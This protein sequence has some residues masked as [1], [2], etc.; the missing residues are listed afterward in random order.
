MEQLFERYQQQNERLDALIR[1]IVAFD[2]AEKQVRERL[3][4]LVGKDVGMAAGCGGLES[5]V[6]FADTMN[7]DFGLMWED[8][9]EGDAWFEWE[10]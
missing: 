2:D 9:L 10:E 4:E 7:L 1:L 6:G 8:A 3:S 5:D